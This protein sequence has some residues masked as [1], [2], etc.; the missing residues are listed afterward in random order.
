MA[1]SVA[2]VLRYAVTA[3]NF[4]HDSENRIH[5]DEVARQHGFRGG[6]VPGVAH[7]AYLTRPVLAVLG[8][9]WLDRG[10]MRARFVRPIYDGDRVEA[11]VEPA[12]AAARSSGR[13]DGGRDAVELGLYDP[14]GGC[15]ALA[16]AGLEPAR[17]DAPEAG[18]STAGT[19]PDPPPEAERPPA[20]VDTLPAGR[21]LGGLDVGPFD[22]GELRS[23]ADQYR[24]DLPL[25]RHG[26]AGVGPPRLHPAYLLH[27][28][29]RLLVA[30]VALGPWIHTASTVRHL[31]PLDPSRRHRLRGRVAE[32]QR[33]RGRDQVALELVLVEQGRGPVAA[34]LHSAIV[35]LPEAAAAV[36]TASA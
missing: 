24:D 12:D 35:R 21:V 19:D 20:S 4:A 1:E 10:W 17:G 30:N 29:N 9:A 28:A 27:A 34:L 3:Y 33:R 15:C 14:D 25:Y 5:S 18:A 13:A 31:A 32:S 26:E 36:E 11:R 2:G 8:D 16:S 7:Y 22:A 23:I 6:L